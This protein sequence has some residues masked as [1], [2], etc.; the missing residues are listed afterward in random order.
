MTIDKE[1]AKK[2]LEVHL[3][4]LE[5]K[6]K[7][8]SITLKDSDE[9]YTL[10]AAQELVSDLQL[11]VGAFAQPETQWERWLTTMG[12]SRSRNAQ[13][14]KAR[15][16]HVA[17]AKQFYAAYGV[18]AALVLRMVQKIWDYYKNALKLY[19]LLKTIM[20]SEDRISKEPEER[21]N[22]GQEHSQEEEPDVVQCT[23]VSSAEDSARE[24]SSGPSGAKR[25]LRQIDDDPP[26]KRFCAMSNGGST[27]IGS[28]P[29]TEL[30]PPEP[31]HPPLAER[32]HEEE[33]VSRTCSQNH[34]LLS[35]DNSESK[36]SYAGQGY[37]AIS[38]DCSIRYKWSGFSAIDMLLKGEKCWKSE[39][40]LWIYH[41]VHRSKVKN[42]PF[43]EL[44][45]A[46][47]ASQL[48]KIESQQGILSTMCLLVLTPTEKLLLEYGYTCFLE[49]V[50]PRSKAP[51]VKRY[52][53]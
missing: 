14:N 7:E 38:T 10:E 50:V 32:L 28:E 53:G 26:Q 24:S 23:P 30:S 42:L 33:A 15:R 17:N 29:P 16:E 40:G 36:C 13:K 8:K 6:I 22:M 46:I 21:L 34:P 31:G 47:E 2:E 52:F 9:D 51:R 41:E 3:F 1:R 48:W 45:D 4:N 12:E 49:A 11:H 44:V 39:D 27:A 5:D 37:A 35:T 20:E 43:L 18:R 25:H 19:N